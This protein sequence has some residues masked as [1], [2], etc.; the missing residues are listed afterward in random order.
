VKDNQAKNIIKNTV[1]YIEEGI[2]KQ[3][4]KKESKYTKILKDNPH[5]IKG[6]ELGNSSKIKGNVKDPKL[7][8]SGL[9]L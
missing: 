2:E 6:P 9:A 1:K 5:L 3:D 7:K 4:K 8:S